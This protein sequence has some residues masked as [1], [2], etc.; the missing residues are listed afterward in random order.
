[1]QRDELTA[2]AGAAPVDAAVPSVTERA[3]RRRGQRTQAERSAVMRGRIQEAT[4]ECLAELGYAGTTFTSVAQRAGVSRGAVQHHYTSRSYLITGAIE[5]LMS[6]ITLNVSSH[7]G[8]RP[9][10]IDCAVQAIDDIWRAAITPPMPVVAE[11][12]VAA[13]TDQEFR[14]SF[15]PIDQAAR[16]TWYTLVSAAL[17]PDAE[18]IADLHLRIDAMLGTVRGL[19]VQLFYQDWNRD[20]TEAAWQVALGDMRDGLARALERGNTVAQDSYER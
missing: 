7:F 18:R 6:R 13:R 16:L 19:S 15:L 3:R 2:Q 14:Q 9:L 1:M 11:L 5:V 17:G 12:R 8:D 10:G 4:L 20:E